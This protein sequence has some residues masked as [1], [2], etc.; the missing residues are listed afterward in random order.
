MTISRITN[1]LF[2]P[3][4][5]NWQRISVQSKTQYGTAISKLLLQRI[6][7][8]CRLNLQLTLATYMCASDSEALPVVYPANCVYC[9][10]FVDCVWAPPPPYEQGLV[11]P[12][13]W[14]PP[15]MLTF[16]PSPQVA[17]RLIVYRLC[18]SGW[19]NWIWISLMVIV[20]GLRLGPHSP[21]QRYCGSSS[22]VKVMLLFLYLKTSWMRC[23]CWQHYRKR[24][25]MWQ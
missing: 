3:W 12:W 15:T 16:S 6:L 9:V 23:C 7:A 14:S 2:N 19:M 24:G 1:S 13:M 4:Q 5:K 22:S 21:C 20:L 10:M 18:E 17:L 8:Y 11:R 25:V